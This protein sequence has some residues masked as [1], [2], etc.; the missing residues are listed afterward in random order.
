MEIN[1]EEMI[2]RYTQLIKCKL[3]RNSIRNL[4]VFLKKGDL[5]GLSFLKSIVY[6]S[7]KYELNVVEIII[8]DNIPINSYMSMIK[9]FDNDN[10]CHNILIMN[11]LYKFLPNVILTKN[12]ENTST[13]CGYAIT[14]LL[15]HFVS[16]KDT[17]FLASKSN[18]GREIYRYL[19]S[20]N[21]NVLS[22]SN[23]DFLQ[24]N[25]RDINF[26]ITGL[27]IPNW[28]DIPD[29]KK[30]DYVLDFGYS[31]VDGKPY[32]D[33]DTSIMKRNNFIG[34]LTALETISRCYR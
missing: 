12:I 27:G 31:I 17:V 19:L 20:K 33:I 21:V 26:L 15:S 2:V 23:I 1:Y 6:E 30:I 3:Q 9:S 8:P 25:I 16:S 22:S 14:S 7:Q 28:I 18:I 32:G 4:F 5:E 29:I 11:N 13:C 24:R 10:D 34:K